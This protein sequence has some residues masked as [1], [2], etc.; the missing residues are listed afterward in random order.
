MTDRTAGYHARLAR[1]GSHL[2]EDGF[3]VEVTSE[4][5]VV[6]NPDVPGCCPGVPMAA[7][8]IT[9]RA[10]PEEGGAPW[11]FTNWGHPIASADE[12]IAAAAE[13]RKTLSGGGG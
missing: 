1:L 13:I 7:D 11:F 2:K 5:V 4:G 12:V 8:T 9:C 6:R 3:H 10:R